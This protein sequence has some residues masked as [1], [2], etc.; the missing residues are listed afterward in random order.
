MKWKHVRLPFFIALF[1]LSFVFYVLNWVGIE[2]DI[3][4]GLEDS[5][6]RDSSVDVISSIRTHLLVQFLLLL[7]IVLSTAGI[8]LSVAQKKR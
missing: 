5:L 1:V 8:I 7:G 3:K 6:D 4:F 2:L